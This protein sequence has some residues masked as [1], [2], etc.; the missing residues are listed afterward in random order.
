MAVVR[1]SVTRRTSEQWRGVRLA[2]K[3]VEGLWTSFALVQG[4]WVGVCVGGWGYLFQLAFV[5]HADWLS[6]HNNAYR[7]SSVNVE[8]S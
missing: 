7:L 2:E 5:S 6:P 1:L 3:A 8:H 4:V